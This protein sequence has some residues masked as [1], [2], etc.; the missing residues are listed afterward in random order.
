[1]DCRHITFSDE[2]VDLSEGIIRI[3]RGINGKSALMD[4]YKSFLPEYFGSNWD[5][6]FDCLRDLSWIRERTVQIVHDDFPRLAPEEAQEY[7]ELLSDAVADWTDDDDHRLLVR[8]PA[9]VK[10]FISTL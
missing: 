7:V 6:L 8:F 3:P 10:P 2:P 9:R 5:S 1:M 4:A